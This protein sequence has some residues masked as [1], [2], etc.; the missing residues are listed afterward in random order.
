LEQSEQSEQPEQPEQ[1]VQPEQPEQSEQL[2][3]SEQSEQPEG[4]FK[5]K[6]TDHLYF[7]SSSFVIFKISSLVFIMIFPF[8]VLASGILLLTHIVYGFRQGL[9]RWFVASQKV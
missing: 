1:L 4:I 5:F 8:L 3:Q 2:E 9:C 6:S 7:N